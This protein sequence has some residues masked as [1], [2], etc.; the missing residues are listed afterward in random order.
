ME[1]YCCNEN[2]P[3]VKAPK[4]FELGIFP[5]Q[6]CCD[7][8]EEDYYTVSYVSSLA[9]QIVSQILS[10]GES[11]EEIDHMII[12]FIICILRHNKIPFFNLSRRAVKWDTFTIGDTLPRHL[13]IVVC[14]SSHY[15]QCTSCQ[16]T[17]WPRS[18]FSALFS[19]FLGAEASILD[20]CFCNPLDGA[21]R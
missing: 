1:D 21:S 18:R 6:F 2:L 9:S 3:E 7:Q 20:E 12:S 17:P 19:G 8:H 14:L 16:E 5:Y 4:C 10:L 13:I 11:V 15:L